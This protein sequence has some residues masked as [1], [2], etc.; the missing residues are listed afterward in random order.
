MKTCVIQTRPGIGDM[1]IFLPYIHIIAKKTNSKICL[2]TKSRSRAKQFLFLDPYVQKIIY[3][4]EDLKKN[5]LEIVKFLKQEK[6]NSVY[7]MQFGFKF[8]LFS[9]L[10]GI[11]AIF[12]YGFLKKN[13][14]ITGFIDKKVRDWLNIS[15]ELLEK[16]CKI[17]LKT[18]NKSKKNIVIGIGGSGKNKK[19]PIE[20]YIQLIAQLKRN[21]K[22]HKFIIAGGH[23]ELGDAEL[24][25]KAFSEEIIS[26]CNMNIK[27]SLEI[28]D[29]S[30]FFVG[31]DTGFMHLCASLN[32]KSFG[33]FGDT[34]S[35][36]AEYNNDIVAVMPKGYSIVKHNDN[37]MKLITVD[38]TLNIIM[39]K[40]SV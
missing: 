27:D 36:Y 4:D 37:A 9:K 26:I 33:L 24:I 20:N 8:Y 10:A 14:S 12:S 39:D 5:K 11:K 6:F 19:W 17:Y 32:M 15:K 30:R 16:K 29:G 13:V 3:L 34:P 35:N 22:D 23:E 1:C 31:N 25:K 18:E 7:I 21:F 40:I 28:I 2:V 38:H